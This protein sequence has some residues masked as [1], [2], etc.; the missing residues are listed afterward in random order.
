M[1][2]D[3]GGVMAAAAD[4]LLHS[5]TASRPPPSTAEFNDRSPLLDGWDAIAFNHWTLGIASRLAVAVCAA[6]APCQPRQS[7]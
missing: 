5:G 3:G 7:P 4:D 2:Y 1:R 6:Q